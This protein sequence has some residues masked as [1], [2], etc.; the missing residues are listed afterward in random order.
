MIRKFALVLALVSTGLASRGQE[1]K[2]AA[3]EPPPV[4]VEITLKGTLDEDPVAISID[5]SPVRD[6][7]KGLIDTIKKAKADKSVKGL[8]LQVRARQR[9]P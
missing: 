2:P 9:G 1:P 5:G 7:L 8:V 6:N 4:V 3:P